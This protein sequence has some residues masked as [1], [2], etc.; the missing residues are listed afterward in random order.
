MAR[1]IL[2]GNTGAWSTAQYNKRR[3]GALR[4]MRPGL[5]GG[6]RITTAQI[7]ARRLNIQKAR[8][9]RKYT[10]KPKKR[11]WQGP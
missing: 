5:K 9:S 8:A 7:R 4:G 6:K 2:Q 11:G 3:R 10:S 1:R